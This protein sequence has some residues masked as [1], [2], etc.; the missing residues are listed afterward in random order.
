LSQVVDLVRFLAGN[1]I[2]EVESALATSL[3]ER[4]TG[5]S[6][7]GL[8]AT[9]DAGRRTGRVTVDDACAVL[10]RLEGGAVAVLVPTR[11]AAG[12]NNALVVELNEPVV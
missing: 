12:N 3:T 6:G 11:V 8:S 2:D 1:E 4:P 7:A 10:A 5:A 9:A